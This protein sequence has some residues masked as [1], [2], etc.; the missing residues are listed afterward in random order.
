MRLSHWHSQHIPSFFSLVV[1]RS[2][3]ASLS[4]ELK[5]QLVL[6]SV[7]KLNIHN[8]LATPES[9]NMVQ[10]TSGLDPPLISKSDMYTLFS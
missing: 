2:P 3:I 7:V 4:G 9:R 10:R 1:I 8:E 5:L 6:L